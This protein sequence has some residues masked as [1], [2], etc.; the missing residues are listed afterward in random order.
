MLPASCT[1]QYTGMLWGNCWKASDK[2]QFQNN[3]DL[4]S[5]QLQ[6][7]TGIGRA[8]WQ[9]GLRVGKHVSIHHLVDTGSVRDGLGLQTHHG[10]SEVLN[11]F[12]PYTVGLP[13]GELS[14]PRSYMGIGAGCL[15]EWLGRKISINC[16]QFVTQ[17]LMRLL[18]YW[19]R[20][21]V[22]VSYINKQKV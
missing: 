22:V 1:L 13:V 19:H 16:V 18:S 20:R 2:R 4:R 17:L 6:V 9:L 14:K 12:V 7:L 3:R 8:A 11:V 15:N 21:K 10:C 5:S